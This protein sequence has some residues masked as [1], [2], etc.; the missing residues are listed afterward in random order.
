M[1]NEIILFDFKGKNVRVVKDKNNDPWFVGKDVCKVLDINYYRDALSKLDKDERGS[2]SLDTLGGLQ[3]FITINE[4]GL[5]T[6]ILRSNKPKAKEFKRWITHE[7][8]PSIRKYGGFVNNVDLFM[9]TLFKLTPKENKPVVRKMVEDY[10]EMQ[11]KIEKDKHKVDFYKAVT[12]CNQSIDVGLTSKVLAR[13]FNFNIGRNRLFSFL[14]DQ[15]VLMENNIPY[16]KFIDK[17][18]FEVAEIH[19]EY[20]NNISQIYFQTKIFQKG[21][22][23]IYNLLGI[24]NEQ[25]DED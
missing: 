3:E 2:V 23:F 25:E 22:E 4:P 10:F 11:N 24:N 21:I 19:K 18:F 12:G 9:N 7:V 5:Y 13:E 6:L 15:R 17:G 16:Q 14:R 8:L 1:D 20:P